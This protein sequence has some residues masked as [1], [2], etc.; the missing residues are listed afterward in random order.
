VEEL[1]LDPAV[2]AALRAEGGEPQ[3]HRASGCEECNFTGYRGRLALLEVLEMKDEVQQQIKNG[4]P[5]TEIRKAALSV[6][7]LDTLHADALW[8][9]HAGDTTLS[10][11]QPYLQLEQFKTAAEAAARSGA[12]TPPA[13][14]ETPKLRILVTDDDPLIRTIVRRTLETQGYFV[15]EA[16]DGLQALAKIAAK[17]PDL[18]L[19]D[20]DMPGMDGFGVLRMLRRK[21]G[22]VKLPVI[23]LT[24]SDDDHSQENA[25]S[26]GA[27]DYVSK[28]VKPG[29]ILARIGALFRRA[30]LTPY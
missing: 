7:A 2:A 23:M 20:L 10:E 25:I 15:E 22:V 12:E 8:H 30:A 1:S 6:D 28:P 16:G 9:L 27:D 11:V 29:I 24:A 14:A 13:P 19:L 4:A 18:M 21:M 17:E 26:L 5:Q 3:Y